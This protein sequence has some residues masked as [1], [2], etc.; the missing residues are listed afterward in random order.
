MAYML[1]KA[2]EVVA[3]MQVDTDAMTRNIQACNGRYASEALMLAL[4]KSKG[5]SRSE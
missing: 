4:I 3:G 1:G 2:K 5:V